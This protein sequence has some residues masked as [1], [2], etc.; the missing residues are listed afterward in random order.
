[1]HQS[2]H[3]I[4]SITIEEI[5]KEERSEDIKSLG[6]TGDYWHRMIVIKD[7][8]GRRFHITLFSDVEGGLEMK[9]KPPRSHKGAKEEA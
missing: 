7:D 2:I 8:A 6:V 3:D 4:V 9:P 1:M 5:E